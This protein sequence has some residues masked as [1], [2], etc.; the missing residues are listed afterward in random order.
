MPRDLP[1]SNGTLLVNFDSRYNLRD[2]YWPHAGERNHSDGHV[3]HAGIWVD[4]DF[5]WLDADG[6]RRELLYERDTLVTRVRL[7]HPDLGV[8][9]LC[10]D[11]IDVGRDILMRRM[12]VR[13]H[14]DALREVRLFFH[15]DW[16]LGEREGAN[17]VCY[18][19]D[20]KAIIAYKDQYYVLVNG[21]VGDASAGES[22]ETR[23][24][25]VGILYWATGHKGYGLEGTWRDAEDGELGRHTIAQGAVDSCVGFHLGAIPPDGSVLCYHWLAVGSSFPAVRNLNQLV[26]ERGPQSFI[27]RTRSYWDLW[28]HQ[29]PVHL[30]DLPEP[31]V[32]LY[33]RSLLILRTQID[34]DGAIVAATDH[35]IWTFGRDSYA[36]MWPRDGAL[37]ANALSH[38]GYSEI[39]R[40]FFQFCARV[41]TDEGYLL[42]KYTPSGAL[43]SSWQP[44]MNGEGE[45]ELPIQEDETALVVYS[46][47]EHYHRFHDVE[48]ISP[49]Y[50]PLIKAAADFMVRYREPHTKLPASSWDLWEERRG[51]HA[52]TVAAVYAGLQAAANFVAAFGEP[53]LAYR[54]RTAAEEIKSATRKYLWHHGRFVRRITVRPDGTIE[55]DMTLDSSMAGLYQFGMF[56]ADSDEIGSTMAA[57]R[58]RLSVKTPVGGVARY[59][60]DYYRQVS[61]DVATVPGNPWFICACWLAEYYI[62]CARNVDE[63]HTALPLLEWVRERALPSGVL[64]EQIHPY[65]NEPLS[66]S[67]LTWSH[68]E[69]VSAVRWY[70]GKYRRF[71]VE[72][73]Q[74]QAQQAHLD[75][76]EAAVLDMVEVAADGT[77]AARSGP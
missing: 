17:T 13:N 26:I 37:V 32:D 8:T 65:T 47:W 19:P 59:E 67:P 21:L 25:D 36:Y 48:F 54:Y 6:W 2:L 76:V 38:S 5:R 68:A 66:V 24:A 29:V 75:V 46:L 72:R 28:I 18:R 15:H 63:L 50:R 45:A 62:A 57:I 49:L 74:A 7:V 20:L 23:Q 77:G 33:K 44:W 30:G 41:I 39:T 22:S 51:I 58:A 16:H 9:L 40:A 3:N 73:V 60:D 55:P 11:A 43:G 14:T 27:D 71:E 34:H 35:D 56:P 4:G 70:A 10:S 61:Q 12:E 53:D 42:H 31:L 64:A 1:L 52:Y 69:Y